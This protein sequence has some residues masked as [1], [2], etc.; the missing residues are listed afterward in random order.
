LIPNFILQFVCL[1]AFG[2]LLAV[3]LSAGV[4]NRCNEHNIACVNQTHFK[5]CVNYSPIDDTLYCGDGKVCTDLGTMCGNKDIFEPA[6]SDSDI[7]CQTCDASRLF[8][9]TSR[10]TFQMCNGAEFTGNV[11]NCPAETVCSINSGKFCV[12]ECEL[13][14]GKFECN[15]VAP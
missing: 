13:P 14:N 6:C 9:C 4:C 8:V 7:D 3:D 15:R 11:L 5:Y 2:C 1:V 12:P 10:T